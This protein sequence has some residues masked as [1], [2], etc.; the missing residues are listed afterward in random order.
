MNRPSELELPFRCMQRLLQQSPVTLSQAPDK[1][2]LRKGV[3]EPGVGGTSGAKLAF[4]SS[5]N[6]PHSSQKVT[7]L[8]SQEAV[9]REIPG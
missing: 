7:D 1:T 6:Y 4:F 3:R 8:S 2:A 9:V 5:L